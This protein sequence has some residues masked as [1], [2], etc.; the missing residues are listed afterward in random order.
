MI[1][2]TIIT[3][4]T[5]LTAGILL[6][7][8]PAKQQGKVRIQAKL[9]WYTVDRAHVNNQPKHNDIA[10]SPETIPVGTNLSS[11]SFF[12]IDL[13]ASV[14]VAADTSGDRLPDTTD[15]F[16]SSDDPQ[17]ETTTALAI[18]KK[19]GKFY[20]GVVATNGPNKQMGS[21]IIANNPQNNF[22]GVKQGGF[23]LGKGTPMGM[24]VVDSPK[25]DILI[26][27]SLFFNQSLFDVDSNDRY[28]ITAYLPGANGVPDGSNSI[29]IIG[30]NSTINN[31]LINFGFGGLA[32]DSKGTLYANVA[33]KVKQ[34]SLTLLTGAIMAFTDSNNDGV[35][36]KPSIFASPSSA[37]PNPITAS[38]LVFI[39]NPSSLMAYGINDVMSQPTQI[40]IYAD[41]NK[42]LQADGL[43]TIFYTSPPA[44]Q[45]SISFFGSGSSAAE[46][47]HLD[48]LDGQAF[49]AF[50]A[51]DSTGN[52]IIDA[53]VALAR[54]DGTGKSAPATRIF[55]APQIGGDLSGITFIVGVPSSGDREAPI[56]TISQPTSGQIFKGGTMANVTFTSSDNVGVVMH[57]ISIAPDGQN[58]SINVATG[59]PGNL[60]SLTFV[61]P[62][63]NSTNAAIRVQAIDNAGNVGTAIVD[64]LIV[65]GDM[66]SPTVTVTSPKDKDKLIGGSSFTITFTST[67]NVG[68]VAQDIQFSPDGGVTFA[69]VATNLAGN[70]SSFMVTVPNMK[71]KKGIIKVIAKDAAG[72][73]GMGLSGVFKIKPKK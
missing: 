50:T 41:T 12:G 68:V 39:D 14:T 26:V 31:N 25:G 65:Q 42:D 60:K 15:T 58:F 46:V 36:D 64:K 16:I 9:P 71:I 27:A 51:F 48:Y 38:S 6:A 1:R 61:V 49:F 56:V 70:I 55:P 73:I 67:D 66:I 30:P 44:F 24:V 72:N 62:T 10:I 20:L 63:I 29:M 2:A 32:L 47:T 40:V 45:G 28:T 37:D 13:N 52:N 21:L 8:P 11:V 54:D 19:T 33:A 59:L 5:L 7:N 23:S 3:L 43:P 53:G 35:P 4:L 22:Q 69:P 57:N 17:N 34:G 18:S